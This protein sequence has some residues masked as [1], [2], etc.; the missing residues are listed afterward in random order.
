MCP[1]DAFLQSY[2]M[3]GGPSVGTGLFSRQVGRKDQ[4]EPQQ[5]LWQWTEPTSSNGC[6]ISRSTKYSTFC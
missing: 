6:A 1:Q 4:Q 3:S 2:A 5:V